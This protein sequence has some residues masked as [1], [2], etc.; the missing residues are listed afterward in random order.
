MVSDFDSGSSPGSQTD[1]LDLAQPASAQGLYA[2]CDPQIAQEWLDRSGLDITQVARA[3][4]LSVTQVRQLLH[5]TDTAFYSSAIR[6]RAYQ[7]VM[8]LLGA[9]E[10][11]THAAV[12]TP[13]RTPADGLRPGLRVQRPNALAVH[14]SLEPKQAVSMTVNTSSRGPIRY[15]AW[16]WLGLALLLGAAT[17]QWWHGWLHLQGPGWHLPRTAPSTQPASPSVAAEDNAS[18]ASAPTEAVNTAQPGPATPPPSA[19]SAEDLS[20]SPPLASPIC[21]YVAQPATTVIPTQAEKPGNYVFV[22]ARSEAEVCVVD[23]DRKVTQLRLKAG[24]HRSVYGPAPWQISGLDLNQINIYFQGWRV[25]LPEVATR[26]VALVER[27]R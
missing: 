10:P 11:A 17:A 7:R 22:Q 19:S 2:E 1:P 9:P 16:A 26:H 18:R 27:S 14:P 5:G 8:R 24:E 3:A 20:A 25:M 21:A 4:C 23:G 15:T 6:R 13:D 12:A